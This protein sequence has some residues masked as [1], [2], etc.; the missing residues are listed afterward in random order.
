MHLPHVSDAKVTRDVPQLQLGQLL[1]QERNPVLMRCRGRGAA[2]RPHTSRELGA[3]AGRTAQGLK[4][5]PGCFPAPRYLWSW[6]G[7]T[8]PGSTGAAWH[9]E[10]VARHGK[11]GEVPVLT[12]WAGHGVRCAEAPALPCSVPSAGGQSWMEH[13]CQGAA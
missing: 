9:L 1:L 11:R 4:R 2:S 3:G 12:P 13:A 7:C 8:S 6:S 10:V 5:W